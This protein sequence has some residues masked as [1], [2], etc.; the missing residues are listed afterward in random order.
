VENLIDNTYI[1]NNAPELDLS[2]YSA[3]T[4]SGIISQASSSVINYCQ[5]D[6]FLQSTVTSERERAHINAAG[7]LI[8]S[9]RRRPV[10]QGD[11]TAIRLRT[12]AVNQSLTLQSGGSDI[13]FIPRPGT[14]AVYPSNYLISFGRGLLALRGANL[15]YEVDYTGGYVQTPTAGYQI[16]P[17]DLQEATLLMVRDILARRYNPM[18]MDMFRQGSMQAMTRRNNGL[19]QFVEAARDLLDQNGY[20]RLVP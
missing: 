17:P 3:T 7:D 19:T 1:Q 10:S 11:V 20:R 12:V 4:V 6:G 2:Q 13:Y 16:V 8:I 14:Y 18:G 15:F 9:F 5:V